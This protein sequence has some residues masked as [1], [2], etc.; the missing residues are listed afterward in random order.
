M[1]VVTRSCYYYNLFIVG[2]CLN[3]N[4][5]IESLL[6]WETCRFARGF[7]DCWPHK[8][9]WFLASE[10]IMDYLCYAFEVRDTHWH[11]NCEVGEC[12]ACTN[13]AQLEPGFNW[14]SFA[15]GNTCTGEGYDEDIGTVELTCFFGAYIIVCQHPPLWQTWLPNVGLLWTV[16]MSVAGQLVSSSHYNG[17][18]WG[19][20]LVGLNRTLGVREEWCWDERKWSE[21]ISVSVSAPKSNEC[22][23]AVK[24]RV[25]ASWCCRPKNDICYMNVCVFTLYVARFPARLLPWNVLV[26]SLV[27]CG[28]KKIMH[29][30]TCSM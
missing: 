22:S 19:D 18:F 27:F 23:C 30:R 14:N 26:G 4:V 25:E 3:G 15:L 1:Q 2:Y 11:G 21:C 24:S 9:H 8:A 12:S 16:C 29:V 7:C 13:S 20:I 10:L 6:W 5:H 17:D 28:S